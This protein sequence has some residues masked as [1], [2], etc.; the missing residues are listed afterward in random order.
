MKDTLQVGDCATLEYVVPE[1]KTV[2][3]LYPE[4][5]AFQTMPKVFATGFM[6]GLLEW[7]CI[8]ALT[9]HLEKGESSLGTF[10]KTTHCAP[11]PPGMTVTVVAVCRQIRSTNNVFWDVTAHDDV[12]LIA[13]AHHGRHIIDTQR[14]LRRVEKK[15]QHLSSMSPPL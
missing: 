6:V 12:E 3:H 9:P 2:P 11:T 10:I 13:Q 1:N 5:D 14:F 7:C 15:T 8:T 4:A